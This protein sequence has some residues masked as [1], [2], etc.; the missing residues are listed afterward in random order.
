MHKIDN[1]HN[2]VQFLKEKEDFEQIKKKTNRF[3]L[4]FKRF[5]VFK[6]FSSTYNIL[7]NK[8]SVVK[9]SSSVVVFFFVFM[10]CP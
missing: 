3:L 5:P 6:S 2:L 8:S 10:I 4:S 1:S 7:K 9:L